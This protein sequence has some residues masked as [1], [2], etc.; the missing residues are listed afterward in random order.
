MSDASPKTKKETLVAQ[1]ASTVSGKRLEAAKK[2]REERQKA[3]ARNRRQWL[4]TKIAAGVIV[5][6]VVGGIVYAVV[7]H[8]QS[9]SDNKIPDGVKSYTYAGGQHD[10]NFN[11]WT[12]NPP[13]GGIHNPVWQKCQ[14]Y[15]APIV[16]GKGV[17]AMEHGAVW[18]TY[19]PDLPQD[20]IDKIKAEA[21]GQDFILASPYPG[22]PA[23]IVLSS[24]N[25]QLQLQS[26]D[27]K[28]VDQYVKVFKDSP[29]Y[30]PEYGATC[31]TGDTDTAPQ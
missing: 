15:S 22:L 8:V 18:I 20:V 14:Y 7:N 4:I 9:S 21:D 16:T 1:P 2:R 10:A 17:H 6:A 29:T 26:W 5:V 30:T 3:Y 27:Q 13:V 19:S 23:P 11:S 31:E 28:T 12:E 25:H 24:W